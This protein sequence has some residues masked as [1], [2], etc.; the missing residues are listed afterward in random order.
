M[1]IA[2][3]TALLVG[4]GI[5][6]L[7]GIGSAIANMSAADRAAAI[8]DKNLQEWMKINIPDPKDQ[9]IALQQ[10]VVEGKLD[11]K[12]ETAIKQDPSEFMKI[13]Q[14][15]GY[16]VAQNRALQQ[17]QD[18]GNQG[19]LNL[20]DKAALQNVQLQQG[21]RAKAQRDAVAAEMARQGAGNSGFA[22]Q[23]Q[24]AG[25]QASQDQ[26]ANS[27]LQIAAQAQDR[28]LQSIMQ[29]GQLAGQLS[30]QDFQQ[31]SQRAAAQDAINRFNTQNLQSVQERNIG[32]QNSAQQFNLQNAQDVSNRNTQTANQQDQY[33]K[34]L[35]QQDYENKLRR[36]AGISG[37]YGQLANLEQQ[38]G[39]QLG[40]TI[41]NIGQGVGGIAGS[42]SNNKIWE[43][44]LNKNKK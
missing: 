44:Y 32:A 30:N 22:L 21:A 41:S 23:A 25:Q 24:L 3:G 19:G 34:G 43:D 39:A 16:K 8:Q 31:Q 11:P 9:K 17:L 1:P 33:N 26:A 37:Q 2:T 38:K 18:I 14:D 29:G 5:S 27:S 35:V 15:A 7:S 13:S 20:S 4:G 6:A 28:A 12:L 36:Q 40:N 42:Y 10:F